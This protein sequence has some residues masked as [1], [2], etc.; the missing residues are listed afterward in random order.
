[1]VWFSAELGPVGE[2]AGT[3]GRLG[4][5]AGDAVAV[6]VVAVAWAPARPGIASTA[7]INKKADLLI[8]PPNFCNAR[9]MSPRLR[10]PQTEFIQNRV[11]ILTVGPANADRG[12]GARETLGSG[13][14]RA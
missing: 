9:I 5:D 11:T 2:L 14:N 10:D 13:M 4:G 12:P 6:D 1:M 7:A 3:M 8:F